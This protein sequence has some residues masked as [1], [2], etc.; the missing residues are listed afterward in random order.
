MIWAL[1]GLAF[2]LA[3]AGFNHTLTLLALRGRAGSPLATA[4]LLSGVYL[5]RMITSFTALFLVRRDVP[6]LMGTLVG[7]VIFRYVL[8]WWHLR[9]E[10]RGS[11]P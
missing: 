1:A 6:T 10:R 8:L 9:A 5:V 4:R 2:G 3:V 11:K 7:L